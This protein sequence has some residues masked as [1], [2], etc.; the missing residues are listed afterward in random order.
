MITVSSHWAPG[1]TSSS[2][3]WGIITNTCYTNHIIGPYHLQLKS[4]NEENYFM[5]STFERF[6]SKSRR[7]GG[8]GQPWQYNCPDLPG[9]LTEVCQEIVG[10]NVNNFCWKLWVVISQSQFVRYWNIFLLSSS[11]H[12]YLTGLLGKNQIIFQ[13]VIIKVQFNNQKWFFA[14]ANNLQYPSTQHRVSADA[15]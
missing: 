1:S 13:A 14:E 12:Y 8:A 2:Q 4:S 3:V 15:Q 10:K 7:G 6:N 9:I 11:Y 5:F